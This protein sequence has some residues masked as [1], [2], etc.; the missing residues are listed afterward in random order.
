VNVY[1]LYHYT[2]LCDTQL[3]DTAMTDV[4]TTRPYVHLD[5]IQ[6]LLVPPSQLNLAEFHTNMNVCPADYSI[7]VRSSLE[8]ILVLL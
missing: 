3:L 4:C 6:T 1:K 7:C 5:V 2:N 8:L